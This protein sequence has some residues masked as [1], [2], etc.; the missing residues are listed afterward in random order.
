M[1]RDNKSDAAT[2]RQKA[3]GLLKKKQFKT[4]L[5]LSEAETKKLIH[6]LGVH[7]IELELQ[8]E[9]LMLAKE[10]AEVASN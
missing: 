6:E 3:E 9:E 2:L 5:Q 10:Q 8:N 4:G 1:K 7:Q